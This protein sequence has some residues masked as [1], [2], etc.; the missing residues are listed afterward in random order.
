[1]KLLRP[2][3]ITPRRE[4]LPISGSVIAILKN[5]DTGEKKV[6]KTRNIITNAGDV[7]YAQQAGDET[8]TNAFDTLWL[9]TATSSAAPAKTS[10]SDDLDF[11]ASSAKLVKATYPLTNDGDADN[12]GAGTDI[13]TW[14]FEYAAGDFNN[15]DIGDGQIGV[16]AHGA[17]EPVLTHF[18]FTGGAFEKTASDTLKVIVNHE[19]LGV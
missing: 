11:I 19:F 14:T 10:D 12:T 18:E 9:G 4:S 3:L 2:S 1:M 16:G 15:A 13:L 8:P 5:L 7:Y 17:A 6:Y